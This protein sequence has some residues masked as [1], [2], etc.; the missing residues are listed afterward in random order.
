MDSKVDVSYRSDYL[1][2]NG[3]PYM[4]CAT[5]KIQSDFDVVLTPSGEKKKCE[6][7]LNIHCTRAKNVISIILIIFF[8]ILFIVCNNMYMGKK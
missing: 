4:D 2:Y 7:P 3:F 8:V 6:I 5:D 1:P